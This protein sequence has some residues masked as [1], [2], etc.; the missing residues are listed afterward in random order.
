MEK[1]IKQLVK[2]SGKILKDKFRKVGV[3]RTKTNV[4]DVV[5]EADLM[6]DALITKRIKKKFPSHAIV[7]EESGEHNKSS[8]KWIIDPLDGTSNFS[9]GLP[10]F[11]TQ[12]AYVEDNKVKFSAI[13]DPIHDELFFAEKNKGSY[14][15]DKRIKVST[16]S[17]F[18]Y[19]QGCV[20]F[21]LT[22]ESLDILRTINTVIH[23]ELFWV[24]NLG[25]AGIHGGLV[26][27]GGLDWV[28]LK[29]CY[30]WDYAPVALLIE[31]AGG[32]A[33][34]LL[35]KDWTLNDRDLIAGNKVFVNK[36]SKLL[37]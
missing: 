35:G 19:S 24:R 36:L 21:G 26:A 28:I 4:L 1:F 3:S 8:K 11:V 29:G 31:E 22:K 27:R 5:T 25:A 6:S 34:N 33:K 18:Q 12:L 13:Y 14:L 7:S 30:V 37:R 17:D 20:D 16:N 9:R 2:D 15:N 10:Q 32:V 23:H